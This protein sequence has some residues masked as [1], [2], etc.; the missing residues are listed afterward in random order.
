MVRAGSCVDASTSGK[1]VVGWA[2]RAE[3]NTDTARVTPS[4]R[5]S[6][7]ASSAENATTNPRRIGGRLGGNA[8]PRQHSS[9]S[10]HVSA[11]SWA[12]VSRRLRDS[13]GPGTS[14]TSVVIT[15]RQFLST[16]GARGRPCCFHAVGPGVAAGAA[17]ADG[18]STMPAEPSTT[19]DVPSAM[20]RV[21][22][23]APF[24]SG[25]PNSRATIAA[26]EKGPPTSVTAAA[27]MLNR[28]VQ[29]GVWRG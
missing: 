19:M 15:T 20:S 26:C 23:T 2:S 9:S 7:S 6:P 11:R 10:S 21:A 5:R 12:S 3:P 27:A 13:P 18:N 1:P 16:I 25:M 17:V 4:S 28:G 8:G 29:I 14:P 24:T 22:S